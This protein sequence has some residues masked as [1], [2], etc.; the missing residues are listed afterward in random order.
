MEGTSS[1]GSEHLV[2]EVGLQVQPCHFLPNSSSFLPPC[3]PCSSRLDRG[4]L[5][6]K[7]RLGW[8]CLVPA[9]GSSWVLSFF[10]CFV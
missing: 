4:L 6:L 2:G 10:L 9:E 3:N 8:P 5:R 1:L 7:G